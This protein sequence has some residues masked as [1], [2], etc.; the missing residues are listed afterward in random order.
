MRRDWV[1]YLRTR[2]LIPKVIVLWV[3]V[4]VAGW[5]VA[6]GAF[7]NLFCA[8]VIAGLGVV[9]FRLMDDLADREHDRDMH[10]ERVLVRSQHIGSFWVNA[11]CLVIVLVVLTTAWLT[12]GRGLGM[13]VLAISLFGIGMAYGSVPHQRKIITAIVLLK[14]P[15]L[16]LLM[17]IEPARV[18]SIVLA[19]LFYAVP[20]ADEALA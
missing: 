12:L 3:A 11:V 15:V 18:S 20:L 1:G 14:Y 10:P 9:A 19:A 16:I 7:P 13:L 2:V 4:S 8:F 5:F 17:A 6:D